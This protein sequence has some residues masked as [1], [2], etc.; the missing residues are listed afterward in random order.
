MDEIMSDNAT[1]AQIAAFGVA[2]KMKGPTPTELAG[3]PP[4]CSTHARRV[5]RSTADAVDIVGTGGDRSGTVNIS[6]MAS[7]VVAAAG[8]PVVKH[9]NRAA[10]SKSGGADVLEALG[11]KHRARPGAGRAVRARGRDRVLFR[12]DLPSRTAF[13]RGPAQGDRHP[14]G[15]QRAGA[16]DQSGAAAGRADRVRVRRSA[17]VIAGVFAPRGSSALV[18]R[19]DDGLDEITTSTITMVR[20][21]AVGGCVRRCWTRRELG[22][23]EGGSGDL[24][25]GDAEANARVAR[26]VFA[27]TT[28]AGA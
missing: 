4:R 16:A 13:R 11:V 20:S 22:I 18:V 8:V 3:S 15:V 24:R 27:G 2:L 28:G 26:D 12:A 10:S 1:S 5:D 23:D 7:V 17:P 6:T 25:G 14:D 21:S 9:G 19:G